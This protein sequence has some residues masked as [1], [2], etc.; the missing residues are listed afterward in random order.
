[1][2]DRLPQLAAVALTA[3][4][5]VLA[6]VWLGREPP[7]EEVECSVAGPPAVR[8]AWIS[9]AAPAAYAVALFSAALA[10]WAG[11]FNRRDRI[12]Q[13]IVLA[14]GALWWA[15]GTATPLWYWSLVA[16]F[17]VMVSVFV[18]PL[19]LVHRVRTKG[20]EAKRGLHALAWWSTVV[21][22]PA[23]VALITGWESDP[24]C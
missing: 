12:A 19:L 22:A 15:T 17:G 16:L 6:V 3:C 1:M 8:D 14:L 7:Y 23:F 4:Y 10:L 20:Q 11:N 2:T 24:F 5:A 9:G 13:A 18:V 21:L